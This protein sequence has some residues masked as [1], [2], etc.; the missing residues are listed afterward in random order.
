MESLCNRHA[1]ALQRF[2]IAASALACKLHDRFHASHTKQT[3]THLMHGKHLDFWKSI[4][5]ALL[6]GFETTAASSSAEVIGST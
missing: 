6:D 1:I 4:T 5:I 3:K 2:A